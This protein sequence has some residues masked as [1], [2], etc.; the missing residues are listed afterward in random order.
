MPWQFEIICT[1]HASLCCYHARVSMPVAAT[2]PASLESTLNIS[3][4][5]TIRISPLLMPGVYTCACRPGLVIRKQ[6]SA[7]SLP[8][9]KTPRIDMACRAILSS[10]LRDKTA[11]AGKYQKTGILHNNNPS[12][13]HRITAQAGVRK[14]KGQSKADSGTGTGAKINAERG[15][16]DQRNTERNSLPD[17]VLWNLEKIRPDDDIRIQPAP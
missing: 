13:R 17:N 4:L 11:R 2:G 16:G 8:I 3:P 1:C 10:G 15:S 5:S 7:V 9:L 6:P 14:N 12:N